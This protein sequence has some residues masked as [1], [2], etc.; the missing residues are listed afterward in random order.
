[1]HQLALEAQAI[2]KELVEAGAL[3]LSEDDLDK[4]AGGLT[5]LSPEYA[6]YF[7]EPIPH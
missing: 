2:C 4:A 1:M 5:L 6:Y 3:E 7:G